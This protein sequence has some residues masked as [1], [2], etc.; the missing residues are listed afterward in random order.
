MHPV[1]TSLFAVLMTIAAPITHVG[2][3]AICAVSEQVSGDHFTFTGHCPR[4]SGIGNT[5]AQ[6]ERNAEMRE[7]VQGAMFR[8][9]AAAAVLPTGDRSGKLNAEGFFGYEV[10]RNS[11]GI[12][13]LLFTDTLRAG[14]S[15]AKQTKTGVSFYT[16]SGETFDLAGLFLNSEEGMEQINR[17]VTSQ[18]SKRGLLTSLQ[19]ANPKVDEKQQFYLTD[20]ELVLVIPEM[21]WFGR[22]MGTAEFIIPLSQMKNCL[23]SAFLQ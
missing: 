16:G 10:K 3:I 1:F 17:E 13:S 5:D 20:T 12:V 14:E 23:K 6:R 21:T 7:Y 15:Y 9:K 19:R 4:F 22:E 18:L 11:G 8:A 2:D